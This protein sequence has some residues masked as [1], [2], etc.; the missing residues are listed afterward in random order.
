MLEN[1]HELT[2]GLQPL[3]RCA[4]VDALLAAVEPPRPEE[5][6]AVEA[7]RRDLARARSLHRAGRYDASRTAVEEAKATLA[8][9]EY[10]PVRTELSLAEGSVLDALGEFDASTAALEQALSVAA[11]W[12]QRSSML[13]AALR[14]MEVIGTKEQSAS[15]L[16]HWPL[17]EGLSRGD[18]LREARARV[19]LGEFLAGQGKTAEAEAEFR[20]VL[21][22]RLEAL[23]PDH[24]DVSTVRNSLAVVLISQGRGKE[25]EAELRAAREHDEARLG[26]EHPDF[27]VV[28]DNLGG[29]LAAQSRYEEAETQLRAA[30]SIRE[31]A[32]GPQHPGVART[33]GNLANVLTQAGKYEEAERE[34]RTTLSVLVETLGPEHPR[35]AFHRLTFANAL[36]TAGKHAQA[37]AEIRTARTALR[38]PLGPDHPNVLLATIVLGSILH[39]R[40]ELPEAEAEL[41]SAL[42]TLPL[43]LGP[44]HPHTRAAQDVLAQVLL[45][46]D[47]P[48]EALGLAERLHAQRTNVEVSPHDLASIDFLLANALWSVEGPAR[49]RVRA[50]ELA[51][52]ARQRYQGLGEA[53]ASSV[54]EVEQ[55]LES[56][57]RP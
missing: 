47:R 40:G 15:A 36:H 26:P 18:P 41:R 30:L 52:D 4:D 39:A 54:R 31:N 16:R 17:V 25:A 5:V 35:A 43:T 51:E 55:W 24:A 12:D 6:A 32:F 13:D 34:Y 22:L 8:D 10:G 42:E 1:V 2:A 23:G 38:Q 45:E 3:S 20:T 50:V 11:Q 37:E 21:A 48:A 28:R 56:H 9:V 7:A 27:A 57:P 53:A 19:T 49:D 14:L 44:D 33:R 46:L 29:A